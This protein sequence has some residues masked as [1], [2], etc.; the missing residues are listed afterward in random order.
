MFSECTLKL[1]VGVTY[2]YFVFSDIKLLSLKYFKFLRTEAQTR[3]KDIIDVPD[4][5]DD[6]IGDEDA[7]P[8]DLADSDVED[9]INVDDDGKD[10][11][12][13]SGRYWISS[14]LDRDLEGD[15]HGTCKNPTIPTRLR[16]KGHALEGRPPNRDYYDRQASDTQ[17]YPSL[18]DTFWRTHTVDGVFPKDEDR[19]IY[20]SGG[21]G[22]D[23][24]SAM[25][26]M[27]EVNDVPT[28]FAGDCILGRG[29]PSDL[30]PSRLFDGDGFPP[31]S[32]MSL[33][34][35]IRNDFW[36]NP[37]LCRVFPATSIDER[38]CKGAT[39]RRI[40]GTKSFVST[41]FTKED[42][43]RSARSER[44]FLTDK[45][46]SSR[47]FHLLGTKASS[48]I[49]RTSL[50]LKTPAPSSSKS[51]HGQGPRKEE[52]KAGKP[53]TSSTNG[54]IDEED[55]VHEV[56]PSRLMGR[57][58]AKRKGKAGTS[59][60]SSATSFDD[61]WLAKL[62][63]NEYANVS[64]PYNVKKRQEMTELLQMKKMELEL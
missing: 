11:G 37:Q 38:R 3:R 6:I 60:T 22:D 19:R 43:S 54:F 24:E 9:L 8:H 30:F 1:A 48:N 62:M 31:S 18:I 57:D 34:E 44:S 15:Q 58:Q 42:T 41:V 56:L 27:A 25:M 52:R 28:S 13:T 64:G 51:S 17:E 12:L 7:L 63:V 36:E 26:R 61:K 49:D 16:S 2:S 32:D 59:S 50:D 39:Q 33:G 5:D 35:S 10:P 4:E 14:P 23:Q 45:F 20:R 46:R 29:F 53:S 40:N 47:N 55:E 21:C